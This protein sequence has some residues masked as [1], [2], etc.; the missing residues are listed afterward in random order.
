MSKR[1][2]VAKVILISYGA[3]DKILIVQSKH[4]WSLPG[5]KS[6]RFEKIGQTMIREL[7]EEI[8][9]EISNT[10]FNVIPKYYRCKDDWHEYIYMFQMSEQEVKVGR[11]IISYDWVPI[12]E[13]PT[14]WRGF[15]QTILQFY[16][17]KKLD[18]KKFEIGYHH[19]IQQEIDDDGL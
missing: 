5:G 6:E 14:Y 7:K 10:K 1:Q 12:Y 15:V 11:E 17:F 3:P 19:L 4:G 13:L 16:Q 18:R 8:N 9:L 2:N